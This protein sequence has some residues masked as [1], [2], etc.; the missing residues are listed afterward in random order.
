MCAN[1]QKAGQRRVLEAY[2]TSSLYVLW[3]STSP[4]RLRK[5]RAE[6]AIEEVP[7]QSSGKSFAEQ[8]SLS[9]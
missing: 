4:L 1:R 3:M 7:Q 8:W 5:Y 2:S 9:E 6:H